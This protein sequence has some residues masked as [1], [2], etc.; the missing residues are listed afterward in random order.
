MTHSKVYWLTCIFLMLFASTAGATTIVLPSDEQLIA[1]FGGIDIL[2]HSVA[3]RET[4]VTLL[5]PAFGQEFGF[6]GPAK[7]F[8]G[9][10]E[11]VAHGYLTCR[12]H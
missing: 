5:L 6:R 12:A 4:E 8:V 9:S 3:F 10:G 1:K 7:R 11:G 2:I